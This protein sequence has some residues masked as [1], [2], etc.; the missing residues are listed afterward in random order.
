MSVRWDEKRQRFI[1]DYYKY[2]TNEE[3]KRIRTRPRITLPASVT[4]HDVAKAIEC[5]FAKSTND[6]GTTTGNF[7]PVRDMFELY[8]RDRK[9]Y[10]MPSTYNNVKWTFD[11]HISKCLGNFL[12]SEMDK[13]HTKIYQHIRQTTG[14]CGRTV[15]KEI[16]Y[17][18][19]FL[20]WCRKEHGI[21]IPDFKYEPL[22][23]AKKTHITLTL[24]E[25]LRL[26]INAEA[27]YA[28]LFL[29]MFLLGLR[30][31]EATG[32]QWEDIDRS[33]GTLRV[34]G[35]GGKSRLLPVP[36]WFFGWLDIITPDNPKGLVFLS[37]GTRNPGG[38]IVNLKTAI[39]RSRKAAGITKHVNPHLLRHTLATQLGGLNINMKQIQ[40]LM[41]HAQQ[42]TTADLYTHLI[43]DHLRPA[44]DTLVS[45]LTETLKNDFLKKG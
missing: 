27:V 36:E 24:Q 11:K 38:R 30:L 10:M 23:H 21:K 35:K 26:V 20:A 8:L 4:D 3:G 31:S 29:A 13:E 45:A 16:A 15:N 18:M 41:R 22:P 28:V 43:I 37:R 19:G 39:E 17:F 12:I 7:T 6:T 1:V 32:L 14:V 9:P 40:L 42:S 2:I 33:N 25:A 5:D 34:V 44:Q